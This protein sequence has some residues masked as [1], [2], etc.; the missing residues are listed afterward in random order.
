[1]NE[2]L[3]RE[4]RRFVEEAK[5]AKKERDK[6]LDEK[7]LVEDKRDTAMAKSLSLEESLIAHH[8]ETTLDQISLDDSRKDLVGV[9]SSSGD[10]G[11]DLAAAKDQG[12]EGKKSNLKEV[13]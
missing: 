13:E 7:R 11:L 9:C 3:V 2:E 1:M 4:G 6:A 12:N 8:Y 5:E 10:T